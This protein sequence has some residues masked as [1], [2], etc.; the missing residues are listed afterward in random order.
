MIF[1]IASKTTVATHNDKLEKW[2][3][4]Y[5]HDTTKGVSGCRKI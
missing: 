1:E 2:N 5:P 3:T 4:D